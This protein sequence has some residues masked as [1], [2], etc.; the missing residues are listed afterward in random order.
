MLRT[1]LFVALSLAAVACGNDSS[2]G[3]AP[4]AAPAPPDAGPHS[5]VKVV[6]SGIGSV[7]SKDG[8]INCSSTCTVDVPLNTAITLGAAPGTDGGGTRMMFT[9]WAGPC[10]GTAPCTFTTKDAAYIVEATFVCPS[11][12]TV[13]C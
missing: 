6:I 7:S 1:T 4:D 9:G 10:T 12:F 5:Q 13:F 11:S 3:S 8:A 2:S